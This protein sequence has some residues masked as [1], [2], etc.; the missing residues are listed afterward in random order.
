LIALLLAVPALTGCWDRLEI[1]DRAVVLGISVDTVPSAGER[2]EQEITHLSGS[3]PAPGGTRVR[4]GVQI[5]LPGRIPLGPG[6]GGGGGQGPSAKTVWVV[7]AVG[8]TL[9]DALMNLQQQIS[10]R[11]FYGHLRVIVVSEALARQG[12]EN[13]N[14]YFRRNSE[15]RRMAW[16]MV[17]SGPALDLMKASP[18]LERVPTLYLMSTMDSA[19]R[20]GKFPVNYVGM[21]WSQSSKRGQ[22]GFLPYVEVKKEQN[23][24][25]KGLAYFKNDRMV[26]FTKPFE[27]AAYMVVKGLNPA[28]YRA[29][30]RLGDPERTVMVYATSRRSK[31]RVSIRNGV[32]HF[33]VDIFTELNLEEKV[34]NELTVNRSEILREIGRQ[35]EK[36]ISIAAE[37]LIEKTK[38]NNSD[39][40]GFGEYVR[41]KVPG[42]WRKHVRTKENWQK[43]YPTI[44]VDLH[45]HSSI[46]R[47]GMKAK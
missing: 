15:I 3:Y 43:I 39:I 33:H 32:P 4:V 45:V 2:S 9:D 42:Y 20:M 17:S 44:Q 18:E 47:I 29:F 22:E 30:V 46:R 19:V 14:D 37:Q 40:F 34:S 35:N 38:K 24:E 41:A 1:E 8:E 7:D 6:E 13:M 11:L 26:G 28:G 23:V 36:S 31:I 21:F 12:L 16:M 5:A 27:I 10:G 25:I